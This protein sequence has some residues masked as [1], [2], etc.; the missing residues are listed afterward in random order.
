MTTEMLKKCMVSRCP[1]RYT[2]RRTGEEYRYSFVSAI[3]YRC[4]E[5]T[6]HIKVSAELT[7]T[8]RNSVTTV[9][10]ESLEPWFPT[11]GEEEKEKEEKTHE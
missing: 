1:V 2:D 10:P 8:N 4:D 9:L 3:L 11:D 6:G 5:G 7:D